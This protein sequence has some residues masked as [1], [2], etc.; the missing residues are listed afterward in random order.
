VEEKET[1]RM[2]NAIAPF[3]VLFTDRFRWILVKA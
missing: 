1:D 3:P 2:V